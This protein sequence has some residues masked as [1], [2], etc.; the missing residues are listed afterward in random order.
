MDGSSGVSA[1]TFLEAP[2]ETTDGVLVC[3]PPY[4]QSREVRQVTKKFAEELQQQG[5]ISRSSSA[6]ASPIC[7][8]RKKDESPRFCVDFRIVNKHLSIPG[9]SLPCIDDVLKSFEGKKLFSVVDLVS[10][11]WQIPLKKEDKHKT[12]FVT[13]K[14]HFKLTRLSVGPPSCLAYF[15]QLRDL[16]IRGMKWTCVIAYIDGIIIFSDSFEDHLRHLQQ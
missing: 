3:K 16:V 12:V 13:A 6:W 1:P 8:A 4:R 5:I 11:F 2:V 9:C 7:I 10:G 15:Q 14:G